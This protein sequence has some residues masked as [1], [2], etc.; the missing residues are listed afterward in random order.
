ML[1]L[2]IGERKKEV[3]DEV[4]KAE[5]RARP[6]KECGRV[7]PLKNSAQKDSVCQ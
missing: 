6:D 1:E 5:V 7:F 4:K 2:G 3:E